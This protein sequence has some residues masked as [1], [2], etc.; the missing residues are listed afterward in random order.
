MRSNSGTVS[1]RLGG[2]AALL[3]GFLVCWVNVTVGIVREDDPAN[4]GFF[5]VVVTAAAC[6]F[7]ARFRAHDMARAMLAVAVVQA[8]LAVVILTAPSTTPEGA[9]RVVIA[10]S[11]LLTLWLSSAALFRVSVRQASERIVS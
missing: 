10:T 3:A 6:A 9:R 5:G 11:V 4:L 7:V 1:Y 8:W 2:A